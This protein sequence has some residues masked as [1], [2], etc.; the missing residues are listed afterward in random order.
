MENSIKYTDYI[1]EGTV[2]PQ[3]VTPTSSN[4]DNIVIFG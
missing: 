3:T 2:I 1:W 4:L